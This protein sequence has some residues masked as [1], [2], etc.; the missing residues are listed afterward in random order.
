M[1]KNH[2]WLLRSISKLFFRL[3]FFPILISSNFSN[4]LLLYKNWPILHCNITR[5]KI[6]K[7]KRSQWWFALKMPKSRP[8]WWL[9]WLDLK[10]T[11]TH[12]ETVLGI[13]SEPRP[14]NSTWV[15]SMTGLN[16]PWSKCELNFSKNSCIILQKLTEKLTTKK[17]WRLRKRYRRQKLT[18]C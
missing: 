7:Q 16:R 18:K 6:L 1:F 14:R 12:R 10:E 15:R 13:G 2:V 11:L 3:Q 17:S 4:I 8:I 5:Q 9:L